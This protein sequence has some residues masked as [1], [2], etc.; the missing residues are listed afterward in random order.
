MI[1]ILITNI[2]PSQSVYIFF[3]CEFRFQI[4][5][6]TAINRHKNGM[7]WQLAKIRLEWISQSNGSIGRP[8]GFVIDR[9]NTS[10]SLYRIAPCLRPPHYYPFSW[11][12]AFWK[13][14]WNQLFRWVCNVDE[15]KLFAYRTQHNTEAHTP[16]TRSHCA[17]VVIHWGTGSALLILETRMFEHSSF[18]LDFESVAGIFVVYW[19]L[20][21]ITA[22]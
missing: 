10:A 13:M 22:D 11:P 7:L 8:L 2:L 20:I 19:S 15:G 17:S 4:Y 14:S 5:F 21:V 3:N 16:R 12:G 1:I 9:L 6:W 18:Y